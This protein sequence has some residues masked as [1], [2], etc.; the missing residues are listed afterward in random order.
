[1][2]ELTNATERTL[3]G[4]V[5]CGKVFF[6][7]KNPK[8]V[9]FGFVLHHK[10]CKDVWI[11]NANPFE[12]QVVQL[13]GDYWALIYREK[14]HDQTITTVV[15]YKNTLWR[16]QFCTVGNN[17]IVEANCG[18]VLVRNENMYGTFKD[19]TEYIGITLRRPDGQVIIS[20]ENDG[21]IKEFETSQYTWT[22][23][24]L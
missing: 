17:T 23:V 24:S 14:W 7:P 2:I 11:N 20:F 22:C 3:I 9:Q 18:Q 10:Y 6:Q 8:I 21:Q 16:D 15:M 1:M 13:R 5:E 12:A 19:V 4:Y